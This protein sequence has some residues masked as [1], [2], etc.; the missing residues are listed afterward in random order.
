MIRR[1]LAG[2]ALLL[3]SAQLLAETL[4]VMVWDNAAS[5]VEAKTYSPGAVTSFGYLADNE[6]GFDALRNMFLR[7]ITFAREPGVKHPELRK[8]EVIEA[9]FRNTDNYYFRL[10]PTRQRILV[11]EVS[12]I[13]PV[14]PY[15]AAPELLI[16]D[17]FLFALEHSEEEK[18]VKHWVEGM[19]L[20]QGVDLE[21]ES[22]DLSAEKAANDLLDALEKTAVCSTSCKEPAKPV[23][24]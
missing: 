5:K 9:Y 4:P 17:R 12:V 8:G 6:P 21:R 14:T 24:Q 7:L 3:L 13:W 2:A 15:D 20:R 11:E 16:N 22:A 1:T 23:L 19:A 10:I 18:I